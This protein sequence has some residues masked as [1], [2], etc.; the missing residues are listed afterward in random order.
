MELLNLP[1]HEGFHRDG[2]LAEPD[3]QVHSKVIVG[4]FPFAFV[5]LRKFVANILKCF[6]L[7]DNKAIVDVKN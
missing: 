1:I 5:A 4:F 2:D 3:V 6:I 7:T